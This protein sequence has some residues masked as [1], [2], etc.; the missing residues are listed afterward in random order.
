M[1]QSDE[2][3]FLQ[4]EEEEEEEELDFSF[5]KDIFA[6]GWNIAGDKHA[7]HF[8]GFC[9]KMEETINLLMEEKKY[10]LNLELRDFDDGAI[11]SF[12]AQIDIVN[13]KGHTEAAMSLVFHN[14]YI[15]LSRIDGG[16]GLGKLLICLI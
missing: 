8:P 14:E 9:Q 12:S 7:E 3:F 6:S 2:E 15:Y 4:E 5:K 1:S 16:K 13:D 11:K 10:K